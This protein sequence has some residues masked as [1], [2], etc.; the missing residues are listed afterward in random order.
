MLEELCRNRVCAWSLFALPCG[1]SVKSSPTLSFQADPILEVAVSVAF[2]RKPLA[3]NF[4]C[5]ELL[6][7]MQADMV[8]QIGCF[9]K[10]FIA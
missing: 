6:S 10:P 3:T 9:H 1:F 2:L 5:V 4:A 8:E 7:F